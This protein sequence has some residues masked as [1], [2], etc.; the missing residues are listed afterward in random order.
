MDADSEA[1]C[2]SHIGHALKLFHRAARTSPELPSH[3][4]DMLVS[5]DCM[6][7]MK[8]S[9]KLLRLSGQ[10][11]LQ[12]LPKAVAQKAFCIGSTIVTSQESECQRLRSKIK[13]LEDQQQTVSRSYFQETVALREKARGANSDATKVWLRDR[14]YWDALNV[15]P[16]EYRDV[17]MD[18]VVEKLKC[19]SNQHVAVTVAELQAH[20][21]AARHQLSQL[22]AEYTR[23][24]GELERVKR[25]NAELE[26]RLEC[27]AKVQKEF[28]KEL[29]EVS[30]WR[31]RSQHAEGRVKIADGHVMESAAQIEQLQKELAGMKES[32]QELSRTQRALND[33]RAVM[34]SQAELDRME[35]QQVHSIIKLLK[36]QSLTPRPSEDAARAFV[37]DVLPRAMNGLEH[38]KR[39]A[40][41]KKLAEVLVGHLRDFSDWAWARQQEDNDR[42]ASEKAHCA[43]LDRL[44]GEL[45]AKHN[46]TVM[47]DMKYKELENIYGEYLRAL[48]IES[49]PVFRSLEERFQQLRVQLE[50][51]RGRTEQLEGEVDQAKHEQEDL[52]VL[53]AEAE[54]CQLHPARMAAMFAELRRTRHEWQAALNANTALRGALE[55]MQQKMNEIRSDAGERHGGEET[56][57]LIDTCNRNVFNRL[58]EDALRRHEDLVE[59]LEAF[60]LGRTTALGEM[61]L[62]VGAGDSNT[63][64]IRSPLLQV[65]AFMKRSRSEPQFLCNSAGLREMFAL[66]TDSLRKMRSSTP[67]EWLNEESVRQSPKKPAAWRR[68]FDSFG[69]GFGSPSSRPNSGGHSAK[70]TSRAA[71]PLLLASQDAERPNSACGFLGS[72]RAPLP[73]SAASKI[74]RPPRLGADVGLATPSPPQAGADVEGDT[75]PTT[76]VAASLAGAMLPSVRPKSAGSCNVKTAPSDRS[77]RRPSSSDRYSPMKP[78]SGKPSGRRP[79][80]GIRLASTRAAKQPNAQFLQFLSTQIQG[81]HVGGG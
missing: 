15:L 7:L 65:W 34:A 38:S 68:R 42:S 76:T 32:L 19:F 48:N 70:H 47:A 60:H 75:T 27:Q 64:D 23:V 46:D 61:R 18:V 80:S 6:A 62:F 10:A 55:A 4:E 41:M 17:A 12:W 28:E 22:K 21:K 67:V 20:L 78:A 26:Q 59:T 77:G 73:D 49:T 52:R 40:S 57:Y 63:Q 2:P 24:A 33:L 81:C 43:E 58:Y 9:E 72:R 3:V 37:T 50:E 56:R 16:E 71:S 69:S 51:A 54:S 29:N 25:A 39:A 14:Y 1:D 45:A 31:Q 74:H 30:V 36:G 66:N 8:A 35:D 44:E 79:L 11:S 53:L 13:T 5:D